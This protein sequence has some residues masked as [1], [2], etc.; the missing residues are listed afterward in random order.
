MRKIIFALFFVFAGAIVTVAQPAGSNETL[1]VEQPVQTASSGEILPAAT[2]DQTATTT[3]MLPIDQGL[4]ELFSRTMAIAQGKAAS[5]TVALEDDENSP[6]QAENQSTAVEAV[7][8]TLQLGGQILDAEKL[9]CAETGMSEADFNLVKTRLIQVLM[10]KNLEKTKKAL[11]GETSGNQMAASGTLSIE[12]QLAQLEARVVKSKEM[13]VRAQNGEAEYYAKHDK[14]IAEQK[15]R[16]AKIEAE[17]SSPEVAK[18]R[19]PKVKQ[20]E[21]ARKKL[22]KLETDRQK[23]YR[24]LETAKKRVEKEEKKL[25]LFR[26]HMNKAKDQIAS[27]GQEIQKF[28]DEVETGFDKFADSEEMKQARLDLPVFELFPGLKPFMVK[29]DK[30]ESDENEEETEE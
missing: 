1:P 8:T 29:P 20:L 26:E 17:L 23:P 13:L 28:Q 15:E 14:K 5:A 16:V 9:A 30:T 7:K 21:V 11:I 24:K 12:E 2:A 4:V 10:F 18:K 22:A 3:G 6:E 25:A 27:M 19:K